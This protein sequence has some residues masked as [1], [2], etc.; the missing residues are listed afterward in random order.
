MEVENQQRTLLQLVAKGQ[1]DR[2]AKES[3]VKQYL[4]RMSTLSRLMWTNPYLRAGLELDDYGQPLY[5][6]G[7]ACKIRRLPMPLN[8]DMIT[9]LFAAISI[10]A[11]L[12]QKRKRRALEKNMM[13][14]TILF[15]HI[16]YSCVS[17]CSCVYMDM[18]N[19]KRI[20]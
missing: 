19:A 6:S 8:E 3:V 12:P 1:R 18:H 16:L 7:K 15:L 20:D 9:A 10:D 17:T 4:S 13:V 14:T 5:Y 11:S 2:T